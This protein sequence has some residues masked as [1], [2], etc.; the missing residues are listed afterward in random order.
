MVHLK[1]STAPW[2]M[3]SMSDS[4]PRT[5]ERNRRRRCGLEFSIP[6]K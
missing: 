2:K 3:A 6:L 4:G 1:V 5:E